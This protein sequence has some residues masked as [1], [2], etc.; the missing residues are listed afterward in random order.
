[1]PALVVLVVQKTV[2][3]GQ[4]V[5][6]NYRGWDNDAVELVV[7]PWGLVEKGSVWY[8]ISRTQGAS[9]RFS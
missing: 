5:R 4:K 6:L 7:E 8:L 9:E 3:A 1:M 2:I